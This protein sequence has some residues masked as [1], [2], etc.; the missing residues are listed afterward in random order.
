M[1]GMRPKYSDIQNLNFV[2][3]LVNRDK[4]ASPPCQPSLPP[5]IAVKINGVPHIDLKSAV[6][7]V[8]GHESR[9][10]SPKRINPLSEFDGFTVQPGAIRD[11]ALFTVRNSYYRILLRN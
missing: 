2:G 8:K 5:N 11:C 1:R 7:K 9:R 10:V 6:R 3:L 4:Y